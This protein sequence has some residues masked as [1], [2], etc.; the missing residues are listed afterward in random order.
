[1]H[2]AW[3]RSGRSLTPSDISVLSVFLA[4]GNGEGVKKSKTGTPTYLV[5][6][7]RLEPFIGTAQ[8]AVHSGKGFMA[9]PLMGQRPIAHTYRWLK[10][11][12]P[13]Y[14]SVAA[15]VGPHLSLASKPI[16]CSTC[17]YKVPLSKVRKLLLADC[18]VSY[19]VFIECAVLCVQN[20]PASQ[21][22]ISAKWS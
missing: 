3:I 2:L 17:I 12:R 21:R 15:Q 7:M 22:V 18:P 20:M 9:F 5:P 6:G 14:I 4:A 19:W 10:G 8:R 16:I 11:S 13:T 1:M